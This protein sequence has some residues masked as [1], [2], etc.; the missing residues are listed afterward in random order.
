MAFVTPSRE[1]EFQAALSS[2]QQAAW[3]TPL[4]DGVLTKV[5]SLDSL[6]APRPSRNARSDRGKF[7]KTHEFATPGGH[8]TRTKDAPISISG[9]L[10]SYVSGWLGA[11]GLGKVVSVQP[12]AGG[13]P[14]VWRH[15]FTF[16][17]PIVSV[18]KQPPVTSI[19]TQ[20]GSAAAFKTKLRALAVARFTI[21]GEARNDLK[22]SADLIGAGERVEDPVTVG[23]PTALSYLDMGGMVFTLGAQAAG[24]D[25]SDRL[26]SF[27][28]EIDQ[29]LDAPN[30][31][32]PGSGLY[33]GR[34]WIGSGRKATWKAQVWLK[35]DSADILDYW[36][37][38]TLLEAK[39]KVTGPLIST[40]YYHDTEIFFPSLRL[41]EVPIGSR[42]GKMVH[43]IA[44]SE[45]DV[46]KDAAAGVTE[47]VRI[48]VTNTESAYLTAS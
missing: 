6:F 35:E 26:V 36:D 13:N 16:F 42:D 10:S 12:D 8:L 11:F 46:Y 2:N 28:A 40:T 4:A 18:T 38:E 31:Y 43:E 23:A 27:G 15:T 34:L 24:V 33:R 9:D 48:V 1:I 7:G 37:D 47:P 41:S 3:A 21:N 17:D 14:T 29:E 44:V 19:Y 39:F 32:H 22:F 5:L 25:L 30:G 20:E 45:N